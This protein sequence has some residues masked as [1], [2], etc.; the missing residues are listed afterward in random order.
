M[1][2]VKDLRLKQGKT[3]L[4]LATEAGMTERYLIMIEKGE[5]NPTLKKLQGLAKALDVEVKDLI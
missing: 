5:C 1:N 2:K 3:R 4:R